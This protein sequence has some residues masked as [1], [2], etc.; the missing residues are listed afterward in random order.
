[1]RKIFFTLFVIC[2][3]LTPFAFFSEVTFLP[4]ESLLLAPIFAL[5]YVAWLIVN[6]SKCKSYR[7]AYCGLGK[8]IDPN[9]LARCNRC[10][11]WFSHQTIY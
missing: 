11:K 3:V 5:V 2:I 6:F 1:M 7:K 9:H 10:R 8:S 4:R